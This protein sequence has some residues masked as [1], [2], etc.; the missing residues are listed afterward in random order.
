MIMISKCVVTISGYGIVIT[1]YDITMSGNT[2]FSMLHFNVRML[3]NIVIYA[4]K[5]ISQDM[6]FL[7]E[8]MTVYYKRIGKKIWKN[9]IN[10]LE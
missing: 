8:D 10:M 1:R 9:D 2:V 3:Q 7:Y 5:L 4:I 6:A